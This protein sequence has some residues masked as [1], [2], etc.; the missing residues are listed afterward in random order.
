MKKTTSPSPSERKGAGRCREKK[1]K[2]GNENSVSG[3]KKISRA[4]DVRVSGF[5]NKSDHEGLFRKKK[6]AFFF[7]KSVVFCNFCFSFAA[8]WVS[9]LGAQKW[10]YLRGLAKFHFRPELARGSQNVRQALGLKN[11][12]EFAG[13]ST[14]TCHSQVI[15]IAKMAKNGQK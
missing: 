13:E 11:D 6:I 7:S 9:I 15:K 3:E 10:P 1:D 5:Q 4:G 14:K 12:A 8:F 2:T